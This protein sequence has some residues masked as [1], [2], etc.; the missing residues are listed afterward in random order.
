[1]RHL[2]LFITI[3]LLA[4]G[5]IKDDGNPG[6]P[7]TDGDRLVSYSFFYD[8]E[9]WDAVDF[10]YND[11]NQIIKA[12]IKLR[13]GS[14]RIAYYFEYDENGRL[15]E[16]FSGHRKETYHYDES[17]T[18]KKILFYVSRDF[19]NTFIQ[20][21]QPGFKFHYDDR[22]KI[23]RK[24]MLFKNDP[25][26]N[27]TYG[28]SIKNYFYQWENGNIVESRAYNRDSVRALTYLYQ[29][30]NKPNYRFKQPAMWYFN[31]KSLSKNNVVEEAIIDH[32]GYYHPRFNCNPC[33][34]R[35]SY[36]NSG[37]PVFQRIGGSTERY[38]K[39]KYE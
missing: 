8:S 32:L 6:F 33:T 9:E 34:K 39:L 18:L 29:Y 10:I 27:Y 4:T 3:I 1:M 7:V 5:C 37:M 28:Y 13:P 36:N 30:D 2:I 26:G 35:Y 38:V 17:G 19:G 12:W 11:N 21:D 25:V 20:G 14:N 15:T 22:G 23:K 31:A 16:V 24:E